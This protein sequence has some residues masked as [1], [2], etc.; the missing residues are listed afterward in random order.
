MDH[1]Q[2]LVE[3]D[4]LVNFYGLADSYHQ[5]VFNFCDVCR[6]NRRLINTASYITEYMKLQAFH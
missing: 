6:C 4:L 2:I 1:P 5:K 3:T